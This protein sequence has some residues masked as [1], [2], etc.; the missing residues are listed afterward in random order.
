[1]NAKSLSIAL[2]LLFTSVSCHD[3]EVV[4]VQTPL[5]RISGRRI[6][7]QYGNKYDTF[8]GIPYAQPPVGRLRFEPPQPIKRY[9]YELQATKLGSPCTQFEVT[10]RKP[11]KV[12]G[13]EDCLY[14]NLYVPVKNNSDSLLPVMIWIFGGALQ[15]GDGDTVHPNV[16]PVRNII[17]VTF[18]H[19]LGPHG[20]KRVQNCA[21]A[22]SVHYHYLSPLSAGLF[23]RGAAG[24]GLAFAPHIMDRNPSATARKLG[25][26]L[27]CPTDN[28]TQL[29]T[30]LRQ[31]PPRVLSEATT[32]IMI[33]GNTPPIPFAP[34]IET[35]GPN[36]F[37][38]RSP[39]DIIYRGEAYDVPLILS[40]VSEEGLYTASQFY[41][42]NTMLKQLNDN[43]TIIAPYL[44]SFY[45]S[46]PRSQQSSVA[47]KIRRHYLGSNEINGSDSNLRPLIEMIGNRLFDIQYEKAARLHAGRNKSPVWTLYYNYRATHSFADAISGSTRHLGVCHGD[48]M[49]LLMNTLGN[50]TD[51][52]DIKVR[53]IMLNMFS[54][55][56]TQ[57]KP[58]INGVK[59]QPFD[60]N[61][62][63]IQFLRLT[64]PT[65]VS[66]ETRYNF[67][68]KNFWSTID[69]DENKISPII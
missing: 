16:F 25:A 33:W 20:K 29:V 15:F 60:P 7:D 61:K 27:R 39:V 38:S 50:M 52:N 22:V 57:G 67:G 30:C 43:W 2:L 53:R 9:E 36:A 68:H 49:H 1:M 47:Q 55:Y 11:D 13:C 5:G 21:G 37:I 51:P 42:N 8:L 40:V 44:L 26:Y 63:R 34:V 32:A 10:S 24:S 3:T 59:W 17:I 41:E 35:P 56:A 62:K 69:F 48:D 64:S 6:P 4:K 31:V 46:I 18:N 66:M 28:S 19:R 54:S 12:S 14:L 65:N 58:R 45:S 23:Q